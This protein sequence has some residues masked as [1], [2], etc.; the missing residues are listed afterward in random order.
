MKNDNILAADLKKFTVVEKNR[1]VAYKYDSPVDTSNITID[2]T[3][4]FSLF[5]MYSLRSLG[6]MFGYMFSYDF[7][8]V[9]VFDT[10]MFIKRQSSKNLD[11][12]GGTELPYKSD[13]INVYSSQDG[14]Y[15]ITGNNLY[16]ILD[17]EMIR[18]K[19]I[20]DEI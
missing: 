10:Y 14:C 17:R 8:W 16:D 4:D 7:K 13:Y 5:S 2:K 11:F 6:I 15:L 9:R 3:R 12:F 18:R 20:K 1:C 19:K